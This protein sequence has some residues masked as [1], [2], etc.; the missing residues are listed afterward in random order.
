L[1]EEHK[2]QEGE[3]SLSFVSL[4]DDN[5]AILINGESKYR[6]LLPKNLARKNSDEKKKLIQD[7]ILDGCNKYGVFYVGG[8]A[9]TNCAKQVVDQLYERHRAAVEKAPKFPYYKAGRLEA[10]GEIRRLVI[11]GYPYQQIWQQLGISQRTF[12]RYLK[13]VFENDREVISQ[14]VLND[15]VLTQTAIVL[16]RFNSMFRSLQEMTNDK[17]IDPF[18]RIDAQKLSGEVALAIIKI[19]RLAPVAVVSDLRKVASLRKML[20]LPQLEELQRRYEEEEQEQEW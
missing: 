13:A 5:T 9:I 11:A 6:M 18:A 10:M 19:Y 12:Y 8:D 3:A 1:T 2:Q 4:S 20:P 14:R 7:L 17:T 16:E 15:E